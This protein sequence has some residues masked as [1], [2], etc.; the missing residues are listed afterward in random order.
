MDFNLS[1]LFQLFPYLNHKY[2][3]C[4]IHK[5]VYNQHIKSI[6]LYKFIDPKNHNEETITYVGE[7]D[8][9]ENMIFPGYL[10]DMYDSLNVG[11]SI[12]KKEKSIYYKVKPKATGKDIMFKFTTTCDDSL[13]KKP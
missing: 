8:K 5:D 7:S 1:C 2:H 6:V 11:D 12:I 10:E 9:E 13:V 3:G 4:Y